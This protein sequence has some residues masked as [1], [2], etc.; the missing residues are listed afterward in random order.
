[1]NC[2]LPCKYF[3]LNPVLGKPIN[4]AL[5]WDSSW[6]TTPPLST[7]HHHYNIYLFLHTASD[8]IVD[9]QTASG[10]ANQTYLIWDII[11]QY[12]AIGSL[13]VARGD[14]PESFLTSSVPLWG[15]VHYTW[16]QSTESEPQKLREW[17]ILSLIVPRIH[18]LMKQRSHFR[19][20]E[21]LMEL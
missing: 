10:E 8:Q 11:D 13:I 15:R 4:K 12:N 5:S 14:G 20:W 6:G 21:W 16:S 1:M 7:W 17:Q 3:N 18:P 19:N 9:V 2:M